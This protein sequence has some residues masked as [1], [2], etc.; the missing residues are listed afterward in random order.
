MSVLSSDPLSFA[1][2]PLLSVRLAD[3]SQPDAGVD[4]ILPCFNPPEGWENGL[5]KHYRI[6]KQQLA[7]APLQ[8]ILVNDGS[9]RQFGSAQI[10]RLETAIPSIVIVSYALNRGKGYAIREGVKRS[11]HRYQI[12]T[13][14]D[15]PFGT[16]AVMAAYVK[17]Q[18][19]ADVVAGE[20]GD[21]YLQALPSRRKMLTLLSR[22]MNRMVLRLHISDAQ[23]GLKGFNARGRE[24]MLSTRVPGFLYDSEFMYKASKDPGLQIQPLPI[25][26]RPGIGF[27][28][29]SVCLLTRE[30]R[31]YL[32]ILQRET[33]KTPWPTTT[34]Y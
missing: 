3:K 30:F 28:S 23:A 7:P 27:S 34:D 15:F 12:C 9:S 20:R 2:V 17:L 25:S 32:K 1:G 24:L 22:T 4:I 19:G 11:R 16:E 6:L 5:I 8:L 13:D 26:C 10:K 29:F 14:L 18:C 21:A 31:N 33:K